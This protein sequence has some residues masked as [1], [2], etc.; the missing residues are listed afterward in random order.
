MARKRRVLSCIVRASSNIKN[1]GRRRP[2][3]FEGGLL[4]LED[5]KINVNKL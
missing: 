1:I 5:Q 4:R 3:L 2:T